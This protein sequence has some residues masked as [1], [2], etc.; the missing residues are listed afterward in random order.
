MTTPNLPERGLDPAHILSITSRT[1]PGQGRAGLAVATDDGV[2]ICLRSR[3]AAGKA[4]AALTRVGYQ[5]TRIDGSR[6]RDLLV[7]GWSAEALETRLEAMRAVFSQLSASS[8]TTASIVIEQFRNLPPGSPARTTSRLI[9]AAHA[10]LRGWVNDHSGIH[11]PHD[12]AIVPADVGNGLRLRAVRALE[13]AIDDLTERQ[14]RV[15]AHALPLYQSLRLHTTE[16]QAKATAI[17][18]ASV[19]YHLPTGQDSRAPG[20]RPAYP[21]GPEPRSPGPPF[22]DGVAGTATGQAASGFPG[23]PL[24]RRLSA[25]PVRPATTSPAVGPRNRAPVPSRPQ[26]PN[27]RKRHR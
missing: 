17:R 18:R 21:P 27:A 8:S 20:A 3:Q 11:A 26:S 5:V 2:R 16:D 25:Q 19:M 7:T 15:A 4:A 14:L 22:G 6:R 13:S 24:P 9:A 23:W 1:I 10:E 12:P